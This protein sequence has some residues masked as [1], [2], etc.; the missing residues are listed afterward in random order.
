MLK[1]SGFVLLMLVLLAGFVPAI[2]AAVPSPTTDPGAKGAAQ[3]D[4]AQP[5]IPATSQLGLIVMVLLVMT[6][7]TSALLGGGIFRGAQGE[8]AA[9]SQVAS[10]ETTGEEALVPGKGSP[11]N[12]SKRAFA[13][14]REQRTQVRKG[15]EISRRGATRAGARR[16]GG[17][18]CRGVR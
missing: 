16:R 17:P 7:S 15:W 1:R 5:A 11:K 18:G 14:R 3:P 10:G 13:S 4:P 9:R 6:A 8:R 2:L 12:R